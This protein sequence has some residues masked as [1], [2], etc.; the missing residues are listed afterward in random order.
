MNTV[1]YLEQRHLQMALEPKSVQFLDYEDLV[2]KIMGTAII[3]AF[4][5]AIARL[6]REE[7]VFSAQRFQVHQINRHFHGRIHYSLPHLQ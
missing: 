7:R 3:V 5:A 6:L 4:V 2:I 1:F